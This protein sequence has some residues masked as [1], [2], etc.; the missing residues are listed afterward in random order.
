[1]QNIYRATSNSDEVV[2]IRADT[3]EEAKRIGE[4]WF[5]DLYKVSWVAREDDYKYTIKPTEGSIS[6]MWFGER[7]YH[8]L[9]DESMI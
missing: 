6:F 4:C 8:D 3:Y 1:M 2:F 9:I 5:T 7:V